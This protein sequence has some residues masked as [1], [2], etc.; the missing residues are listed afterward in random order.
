MES[1]EMQVVEYHNPK[2]DS[3][4]RVHR[5]YLKK[6]RRPAPDTSAVASNLKTVFD[7][8]FLVVTFKDCDGNSC[9]HLYPECE[10]A[11]LERCPA[12]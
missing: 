1:N 5:V 6:P 8:G 9:S 7:D 2:G 11:R 3:G 4:P 12:R 10:V